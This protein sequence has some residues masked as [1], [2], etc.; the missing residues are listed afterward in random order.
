MSRNNST[1][2]HA[3]H[4]FRD[5]IPKYHRVER[6]RLNV[7]KTFY[8]MLYFEYLC[9]RFWISLS[10]SLSLYG[11]YYR[12]INEI[13][14]PEIKLAAAKSAYQKLV[15]ISTM[16]GRN[17]WCFYHRARITRGE[18]LRNKKRT[19]YKYTYIERRDRRG[20]IK[21]LISPRISKSNYQRWI[22]LL[23][24]RIGLSKALSQQ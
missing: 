14:I 12:Y 21:I 19:G 11:I 2:F 13:A 7:T 8:E 23:K 6:I 15:D 3:P 5:I 10:P 20:R 17:G 1:Q 4:D 16:N 9:A 24:Y 22:I 18:I